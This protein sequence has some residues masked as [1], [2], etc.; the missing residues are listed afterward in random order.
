MLVLI[1]HLC[2]ILY[3]SA[4][5]IIGG[6]YPTKLRN[7]NV[8]VSQSILDASPSSSSTSC[9][10]SISTSPPFLSLGFPSFHSHKCSG[11]CRLPCLCVAPL[12]LPPTRF[13]SYYFTKLRYGMKR[14][15]CR[16]SFLSN[17]LIVFVLLVGMHVPSSFNSLVSFPPFPLLLL[18]ACYPSCRRLACCFSVFLLV[19][20][21]PVGVLSPSLTSLVFFPTVLL[22]SMFLGWRWLSG[23][24]SS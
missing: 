13:L 4:V 17:F 6:F 21:L 20:V 22:I 8:I 1:P 3:G 9:A 24:P 7:S 14:V 16:L 2:L 11:I 5:P 12:P 10:L 19:I 23:S 18:A 15:I